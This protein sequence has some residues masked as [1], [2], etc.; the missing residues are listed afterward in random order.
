[1]AEFKELLDMTGSIWLPEDVVISTCGIPKDAVMTTRY[2]QVFYTLPSYAATERYIAKRLVSKLYEKR[3][4]ISDETILALLHE[5][6]ALKNCTLSDEQASAV[7]SA[8]QNPIS[9]IT[10]GPGT[11]KTRFIEAVTYVYKRLGKTRILLCAPT[12]KA[13]RRMEESIH[14]LAQTA[15]KAMKLSPYSK[16]LKRLIADLLVIDETSMLDMETMSFLMQAVSEGTNLLF[17][18]DIK[19]LPSVGAGAILRDMIESGII[20]TTYF[21]KIYR[22]KEDDTVFGNIQKILYGQEDLTYDEK[23]EFK[24]CADSTP[25][26]IV[27]EYIRAA[28]EY[29]IEN[30]CCLSPYKRKG[31]CCSN[32]LNNKIQAKLNPK[33]ARPFWCGTVTEI[34]ETDAKTVYIQVGDPVMHLLNEDVS[35]GDIGIVISADKDSVV[36]DYSGYKKSYRR[37]EMGHLTHAYSISIHKSQGSE[38]KKC[39]V[40]S[41]RNQLDI[42]LNC[43]AICY[44]HTLKCN[45]TIKF[46]FNRHRILYAGIFNA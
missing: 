40:V 33:G 18:G 23:F 28:K 17:T 22:Q 39:L 9:V 46:I 3:V 16:K 2:N 8:V 27:N 24:N 25:D 41:T 43:I 7:V 38:Y 29:G 10:G 37:K 12:G 21:T 45:L 11:G 19:Q 20:P 31:Y 4:F 42:C 5:W 34:G 30:I 44:P 35:N 36:V 26:I 13:A 15:Q 14:M 1:M 32:S 6:E